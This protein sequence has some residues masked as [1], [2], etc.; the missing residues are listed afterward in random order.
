MP[1]AE[2]IARATSSPTRSRQ[3]FRPATAVTDLDGAR[4]QGGPQRA[5]RQ[6]GLVDGMFVD[7]PTQAYASAQRIEDGHGGH[8]HLGR[9][10]RA[11]SAGCSVPGDRVDIIIQRPGHGRPESTRGSARTRSAKGPA[12]P[13]ADLR[14]RYL[15]QNSKVLAIGSQHAGPRRDGRRDAER[16]RPRLLGRRAT[17]SPRGAPGR[18][19]QAGPR[20]AR[21]NDL[22][23]TL[24]STWPP[25]TDGTLGGRPAT[26]RSSARR[27]ITPCSTGRAPPTPRLTRGS[28]AASSSSTTPSLAEHRRPTAACPM[29]TNSADFGG[30]RRVAWRSSRP[31][32]RRARRLALQLGAAE[33]GRTPTAPRWRRSTSRVAAPAPLAGRARPVLRRDASLGSR[34]APAGARPETGVILVVDELSHRGAPAAPCGPACATSLASPD[35]PAALSRRSAGSA[36]WYC[37]LAGAPSVGAGRHDDR[38]RRPAHHRLLDQGRR[39]QVG[40]RLQPRRRPGQAQRPAAWSWSTPTSSSATSP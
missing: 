24:P 28:T 13:A 16:R 2:L 40:D 5:R 19:P 31:T 18:R 20:S 1:G 10:G 32:R 6:P 8:H 23:G 26:T 4:E 35:R 11:A 38:R 34:R 21:S 39:R 30:H 33:V 12:P 14:R 3:E 25:A 9:P 22:C 17:S 36:T 27:L 7:P 37:S 15:Y 29:I